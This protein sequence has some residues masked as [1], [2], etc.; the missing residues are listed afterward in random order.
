MLGASP[1]STEDAVNMTVQMRKKRLRPRAPASHPVAGRITAL[2]ARY[3]VSTHETSST[4]AD[5][6]P[7]MWGR[8]TLVTVTSRTCITVTNITAPVIVHFRAAPTSMAVGERPRRRLDGR[9]AAS[10][11]L[12]RQRSR[13][14]SAASAYVA[15]RRSRATLGHGPKLDTVALQLVELREHAIAINHDASPPRPHRNRRP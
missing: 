13:L 5:S 3:D 8:A 12:D 9:G 7:W 6:E 11:P 14:S 4:P 1:Q 10:R 2:A 15:N